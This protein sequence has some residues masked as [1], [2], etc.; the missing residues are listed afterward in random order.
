[1]KANNLTGEYCQN[2]ASLLDDVQRNHRRVI[3]LDS[4]CLAVYQ[5]SGDASRLDE[6]VKAPAA[7][8]AVAA[9]TTSATTSEAELKLAKV[10]KRGKK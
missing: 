10:A 1:M 6:L 9:T 2:C 4:Q 7:P 3:V 5:Q 8:A